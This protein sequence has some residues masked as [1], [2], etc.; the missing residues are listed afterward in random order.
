MKKISLLAVLFVA[1]AASAQAQQITGEYV[2]TR[3]ADVYTGHCFANSETGLMGDQAIVAWRISKGEWNGVKLDGLHVVGV[4][5][6][7]DTLGSQY[8][9]PFPAKAVLIFDERATAEQRSAL[10]AFAQEMGGRMFENVVRTE[11]APIKLDMEYHGE[12]PMAA[13]VEAGNLATINTRPIMGKDKI[14]GHEETYYAPLTPTA[15]TM[16]AV[17]ELDQF[18][19]TGLNSVWSLSGKRSAF[20]GN[21]VR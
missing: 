11:T 1:L 10:Q 5:K 15:H 8:T 17:A 16:P 21:F 13:R 14:C 3:N 2:E 20:V 12:H 9:N 7:A 19:G 6:A 18:K 4:T